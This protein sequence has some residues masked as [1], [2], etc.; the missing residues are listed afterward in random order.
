MREKVDTARIRISMF[1]RAIP[2]TGVNWLLYSYNYENSVS[3]QVTTSF[4][5][6]PK[7]NATQL[8]HHLIR[9]NTSKG[10]VMS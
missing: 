10:Q 1:E 8:R 7:T 4:H 3:M 9:V 2:M 6:K 5:K